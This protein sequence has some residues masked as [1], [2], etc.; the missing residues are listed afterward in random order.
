VLRDHF[1]RWPADRI[2]AEKAKGFSA[3]VARLRAGAPVVPWRI[4]RI[5]NVLNGIEYFIHHEDVRRANGRGPRN[6]IDDLD[7]LAWRM[8]RFTGRRLA[9]GIRPFGL[10]LVR[11]DGAHHV[12]GSGS[13]AV[14]RGRP[15]ELLLFVAGRRSTA[16]VTVEGEPDAVAAVERAQTTL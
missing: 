11:P 10:E 8:T 14:L 13:T 9:R 15:T 5:R 16:Q 1:R 12:F 2:A 3:L 4:P 6:D 7:A